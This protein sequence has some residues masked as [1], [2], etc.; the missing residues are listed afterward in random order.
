VSINIRDDYRQSYVAFLDLLGFKAAVDEAD[1]D[2]AKQSFILEI[3]HLVKDTLCENPHTRMRLSY[4]SDCLIAS[5]DR[6]PRG[7]YELIVSI[8]TL[9]VNLLQRDV[10]VRGGLAAGG[11]HHSD[12]FVYGK[13][14]NKAVIMETR[15]E[16]P[17]TL[18]SSEAVSDAKEYGLV[19]TGLLASTNDRL[20]VDLFEHVSRLSTISQPFRHGHTR[21][22]CS[23]HRSFNP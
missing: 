16:Y 18:L 14:V 6:T 12:G 20:F 23:P 13:A 17:R 11:A 10:L 4:F 22:A 3:L 7:L 9:T 2:P 19:E 1:S 15:A 21:Q 5:V 8:S